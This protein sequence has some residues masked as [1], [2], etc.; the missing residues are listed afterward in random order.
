V[1]FS[2]DQPLI[3]TIG[4]KP[5]SVTKVKHGVT[6]ISL[7]DGRLVRL[8]MHVDGVKEHDDKLDV[9]YQAIVEVME[10]PS[11]QIQDVHETVQ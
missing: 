7:S 1:K 11:A 2:Y 10:E 9:N 8:S 6:E 3:Y 5:L 4:P